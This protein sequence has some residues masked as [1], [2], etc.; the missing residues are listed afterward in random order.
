MFVGKARFTYND[1]TYNI[2]KCDISIGND[3]LYKNNEFN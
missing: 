1:F 3:I 2:N